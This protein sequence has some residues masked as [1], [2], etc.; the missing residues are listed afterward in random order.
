M[1]L[2]ASSDDSAYGLMAPTWCGGWMSA[3]TT[4]QYL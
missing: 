3:A 2:D 1:E 4:Q